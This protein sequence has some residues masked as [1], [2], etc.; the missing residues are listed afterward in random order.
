MAVEQV[1]VLVIGAGPS[2]TVAASII[3]K[4]GFKVKIVEKEQFP[5]FVIGES[6]L[7]KC[8]EPLEEA[9]FLPYIEAKGF[10]EKFGAK[11]VNSDRQVMDFNFSDQYT[12]GWSQTWQVKRADFD[13]TL[14]KAV[15]EM[16]VSVEYKTTVTNIEFSG[17]D[18]VTTV[19]DADGTERQIAAKFIVDG[20]GYGRVIPR[21]FGLERPSTL[22]PRKTLFTHIKDVRRNNY[23]EPNRI[24]II[25][26]APGV[27][28][29]CIPF[30]DGITSCGFVGEP[31]FFDDFKGTP[32]EQLRAIIASDTNAAERFEGC[33]FVF[34]PRV[35]Q[36]WSVSCDKFFGDGFVLTGNVTEFLDP[37]FSSGVTLA[38]VSSQR[39]AHLVIKQLQGQQ[40]DWQK[41]YMDE[42][43]IGVEAFRTYVM[44]WYDGR[45]QKIFFNEYR[46]KDVVDKICSVLAGYVWD[47]SNPYVK[48]SESSVNRLVRIISLS[49]QISNA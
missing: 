38:T 12:K 39:A 42:C 22:P 37:V 1:D 3:N 47:L 14:A 21:M 6:L 33:E 26:H 10:Q 46:H 48:D 16:G 31:S 5:R 4:A 25:D 23:V 27:W 15:E 18:S 36:S 20:S 19:T 43:M 17:T 13:H 35:L 29:W 45:L 7:P 41:E 30:S 44:A 40:V 2:G 34:E 32:E 11:F 28:A 9:G 49:N 8:M 24:L